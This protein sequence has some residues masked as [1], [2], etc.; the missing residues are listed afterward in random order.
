MAGEKIFFFKPTKLSCGAENPFG[1]GSNIELNNLATRHGAGVFNTQG[2][3][4]VIDLQIRVFKA[5]I[6]QS[7]AKGISY[8]LTCLVRELRGFEKIALLPGESRTVNF[9]LDNRS[10]AVWS[11]GWR[12]PA[13]EYVIEV[14]SSSRD[15]RLS[16]RIRI[17]GERIESN[18]P[19]SWYHTLAGIP[20][21]E[22]WE[23][24]MGHSVPL[25][26]EPKRGEFTMDNSCLEMKKYS[27]MMKI[28][29]LVTKSIIAKGIEGKKDMSN[30]TYKMMI[31]SAV[32]CPMRS[33]VINSGGMMGE[34]LARGMVLMA[35]GKLFRGISAMMKK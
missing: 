25:S 29:Y 15:I 27:L 13:G 26:Q 7:V 11:D 9:T 23:T 30:P 21:R 4:F 5:G 2:Y 34:S 19:N 12:I 1:L 31:T 18:C 33:A 6:R 14:G 17:S 8:F 20:T 32:D 16:G 24:L 3:V 35:N 28:Q 10:C 22:E